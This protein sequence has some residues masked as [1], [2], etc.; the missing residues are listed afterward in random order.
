M[1]SQLTGYPKESPDGVTLPVG[2]DYNLYFPGGS[3]TIGRVLLDD[4]V[5]YKNGTRAT[6]SQ[7]ARNVTTFLHWAAEPE[8]DEK[9]KIV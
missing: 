1:F 3:S 8:L 9:K 2:T 4:L 7:L 5:E 6:T